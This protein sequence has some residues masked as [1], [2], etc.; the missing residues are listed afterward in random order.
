MYTHMHEEYAFTGSLTVFSAPTLYTHTTLKEAVLIM[1]SSS[2]FQV[3]K[4][5]IRDKDFNGIQMSW[6][7]YVCV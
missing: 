7:V 4:L 5:L 6:C 2:S 3:I 1:M